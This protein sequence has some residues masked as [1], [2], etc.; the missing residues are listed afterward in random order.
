MTTPAP[1]SPETAALAARN[2]LGAL[3]DVFTP[4]RLGCFMFAAYLNAVFWGLVFFVIPGV[5]VYWWLRRFPDFNRKQAAKRLCLFEHGMIVDA[6]LSDDVAVLRW[7]SVR[8]YQDITQKVINGVPH[9]A[10]HVYTAMATTGPGAEITGFYSAPEVWGPR[11]QEAILRA[12]GQAMLDAIHAGEAVNFSSFTL[13]S[14]GLA[15]R[16]SRLPWP[17][18][19]GIEIKAG[20][21][22]VSKAGDPVHWVRTPASEVANLHLFLALTDHLRG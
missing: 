17:E 3:Q 22:H 14:A 12:Q 9:P 19:Q 10:S 13:S 11:M 15:A 1:L 20:W 6:R 5:I 18:V 8:L 7:D 2:D 4:Q 16:G 21:I